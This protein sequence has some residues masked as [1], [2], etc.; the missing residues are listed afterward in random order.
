M[1]YHARVGIGR[2]LESILEGFVK[3]EGRSPKSI[4][5]WLGVTVISAGVIIGEEDILIGR[6][7]RLGGRGFAGCEEGWLRS[8][9]LREMRVW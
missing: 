4:A 5:S 1:G 2:V 3:I 7:T 9:D 8:T 6:F